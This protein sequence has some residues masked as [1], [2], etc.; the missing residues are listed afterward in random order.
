LKGSVEVDV[1]AIA[2]KQLDHLQSGATVKT[3]T[4]EHQQWR[5]L[6][7]SGSRPPITS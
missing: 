1:V 6:V 5:R 2:G 4:V 7:I 3:P